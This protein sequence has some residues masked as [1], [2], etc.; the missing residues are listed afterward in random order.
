MRQ[1]G[2]T[3]GSMR[4]CL[5][6]LGNV[7][8]VHPL[9]SSRTYILNGLILC[10]GCIRFTVICSHTYCSLDGKSS[11]SSCSFCFFEAYACSA[12]TARVHCFTETWE[13]INSVFAMVYTLEV[14]IY[15]VFVPLPL[16][17]QLSQHVDL[18]GT[19]L[20]YVQRSNVQSRT[21]STQV[22]IALQT[23][24]LSGTRL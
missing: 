24:L 23:P 12:C 3:R 10:S 14:K 15:A 8:I 19:S 18:L 9:K 13:S 20:C 11:V 6:G 16:V 21:S 5:S 4:G 1:T 2:V 22:S 17:P 7:T